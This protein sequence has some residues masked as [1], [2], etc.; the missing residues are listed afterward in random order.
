MEDAPR[1][2]IVSAAARPRTAHCCR[3]A[4]GVTIATQFY[5]VITDSY[6]DLGETELALIVTSCS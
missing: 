6:L 2:P 3:T 5:T 1:R 4:E